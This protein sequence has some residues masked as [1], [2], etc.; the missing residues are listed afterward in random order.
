MS[1]SLSDLIYGSR[2]KHNLDR[3]STKFRQDDGPDLCQSTRLNSHQHSPK[4]VTINEDV[5]NYYRERA[6]QS[7]SKIRHKRKRDK[8]DFE[9]N[10]EDRLFLGVLQVQP[11][12]TSGRAPKRKNVFDPTLGIYIRVTDETD[13]EKE[14]RMQKVKERQRWKVRLEK[15]QKWN[16][17]QEID[18]G[19]AFE[20]MVH[21]RRNSKT[22]DDERPVRKRR[23]IGVDAQPHSQSQLDNLLSQTKSLDE[24]VAMISDPKEDPS[25]PLHYVWLGYS[26]PLWRQLDVNYL[27]WLESFY[28][29]A[30]KDHDTLRILFIAAAHKDS[31]L[32]RDRR[33]IMQMY[34]KMN[35][36]KYFKFNACITNLILTQ[37]ED[38]RKCPNVFYSK[39]KGFLKQRARGREKM[40]KKSDEEF[41]TVSSLISRYITGCAPLPSSPKQHLFVKQMLN[42]LHNSSSITDLSRSLLRQ[43]QTLA[44]NWAL[45]NEIHLT[46]MNLRSDDILS[47]EDYLIMRKEL[48]SSF[49]EFFTD[50][51]LTANKT[52]CSDIGASRR[53]LIMNFIKSLKNKDVDTDPDAVRA[54]VQD[55]LKK[56]QKSAA[57]EPWSLTWTLKLAKDLKFNDLPSSHGTFFSKVAHSTPI[58]LE[59]IRFTLSFLLNLMSLAARDEKNG[60]QDVLKMHQEVDLFFSKLAAIVWKRNASDAP[61]YLDK[62]VLS[63]PLAHVSQMKQSYISNSGYVDGIKH[64]PYD[65]HDTPYDTDDDASLQMSVDDNGN[66]ITGSLVDFKN[67]AFNLASYGQVLARDARVKNFYQIHLTTV[68][69][70]IANYFG[71]AGAKILGRPTFTGGMSRDT[72]FDL[73][74]LALEDA[75]QNG[76]IKRISTSIDYIDN[77]INVDDLIR[78]FQTAADVLLDIMTYAPNNIDCRCWYTAT[79]VGA[80]IVA[81]GIPIGRGARVACPYAYS[82]EDC[83]Y[84]DISRHSKYNELRSAASEAFQDFLSIA[85]ISACQGH[86]YNYA[87]KSLLEWNE[88]IALLIMRPH[89]NM[90]AFQTIK[91]LHARHTI[92]WAY[93]ECSDESFTYVMNLA[94]DGFISLYDIMDFLT[95]LI[96][97][98][99]HNIAAW[100]ALASALIHLEQTTTRKKSLD[101]WASNV[102]SYWRNLYFSVPS[103]SVSS[104][105]S[106]AAQIST[107]QTQLK[108]VHMENNLNHRMNKTVWCR[109]KRKIS[110]R[111]NITD[112]IWPTTVS[113][114]DEDEDDHLEWMDDDGEMKMLDE[115]LPA[116][117]FRNENK[118]CLSCF[119]TIT[120]RNRESI[121]YASKAIVAHTLYGPCPFV[122]LAVDFLA[123]QITTSTAREVDVHVKNGHVHKPCDATLLLHFLTAAKLNVLGIL[124]EL[125]LPFKVQQKTKKRKYH[126]PLHF[127]KF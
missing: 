92:S 25:H 62:F 127:G 16:F 39:R 58:S 125:L 38:A 2:E 107:A 115:Y 42:L 37:N 109:L 65:H 119:G 52:H 71:S 103:D 122:K 36:S 80:M 31:R 29:H 49:S 90:G 118:F 121:L 100:A 73:I 112:W 59:A 114:E 67:I 101:A 72:P 111:T 79:R 32:S 48:L 50:P 19:N 124:D 120:E 46:L 94:L 108:D 18:V 28:G 12:K 17:R 33:S 5:D 86:R 10:V 117:G 113:G 81:S 82:V 8:Y 60:R 45:W 76:S 105:F 6:G 61:T 51:C 1:L 75:A 78:E 43:S 110:C 63:A 106:N 13:E 21:K 53:L 66:N 93:G 54:A 98:E 3:A 55:D 44:N 97:K 123:H 69:A 34:L 102:L 11:P 47:S 24:P 83:S 35:S 23:N 7:T 40:V 20:F 56:Q 70:T 15:N 84:S 4:R 74:R 26:A 22:A 116:H 27:S 89:L 87:M 104:R 126:F 91:K 88:G 14:I 64:H 96:D 41:K 77:V 30:H 57:D 68:I 9:S 95:R 85:R 99:P